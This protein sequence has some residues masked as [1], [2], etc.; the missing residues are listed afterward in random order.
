M[1]HM[2]MNFFCDYEITTDGRIWSNKSNKYLKPQNNG[3]GYLKVTLMHE[4]KRYQRYVHRLV[5]F[6]FI[7]SDV[8]CPEVDHID[9]DKTNN[10][11]SNLRWVSRSENSKN[12]CRKSRKG[13]TTVHRTDTEVRAIL[14]LHRKG[15]SSVEIG[16]YFDIPRQTVYSIIKRYKGE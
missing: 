7:A 6:H 9:G 8:D 12:F 1:E 15:K 10:H 14:A 3:N 13:K 11:V 2:L 4:G 5:A 16:K